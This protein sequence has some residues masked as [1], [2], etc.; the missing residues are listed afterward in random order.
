M[1]ALINRLTLFIAD[2]RQSTNFKLSESTKVQ[3]R[4]RK[5][6]QNWRYL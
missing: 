3:I 5:R 1:K 6:R 2:E 4:P